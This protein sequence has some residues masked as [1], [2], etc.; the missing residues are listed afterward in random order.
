MTVCAI[1]VCR[2]YK[3]RAKNTKQITYHQ[4][5][6]NPIIRNQWIDRIRKSR[7]EAT[8]KPTKTTVVCSD[9]FRS[10]DI[11]S[12]DKTGRRRLTKE[13]VPR[14]ALFLSSVQSS[15]SEDSDG[16]ELAEKSNSNEAGPS[17]TQ[18][19]DNDSN[20][21]DTDQVPNNGQSDA[22][23]N[24]EIVEL[25]NKTEFD[26]ENSFSDL[27][28][29]FDTP[30]EAKLRRDLWRKIVLERKHCLQIKSLRQ[31]NLRLKK[32]IAS[33]KQMMETLKKERY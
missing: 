11:H 28:S 12:V 15:E 13:A 3:G 2:N 22:T 23:I 6:S 7:G 16:I 9:H 21:N 4:I 5:P 19:T 31:K 24:D 18:S 27:D 26:E 25:Q 20:I 32:K 17:G 29:I 8:W 10:K 14:K 1:K 33:L 30:K